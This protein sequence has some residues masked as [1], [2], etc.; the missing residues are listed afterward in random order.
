M[1]RVWIC[2]GDKKITHGDYSLIAVQDEDIENIR[3]WRN[4]QVSVLRQPFPIS[5]EQ[6]ISYY[7]D[8]IFPSMQEKEPINI[9]ISFYFKGELIGYG[10]LVHI[11]WEDSRG[12]L[13]FLLNPVFTKDKKLYKEKHMVFLKLVSDLAFKKLGLNKVFTETWAIRK[14]H[15]E[16]LERFGFQCEGRL[17]SHVIINGK[18]EDALIHR[19]LS[20]EYSQRDI[21]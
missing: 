10:G 14:D 15:I 4:S 6:Q 19:I 1:S 13:S 12:E 2:L 20:T 17:K 5:R 3:L 7:A 18:L 11:S 8:K 16:N 9:L 21:S